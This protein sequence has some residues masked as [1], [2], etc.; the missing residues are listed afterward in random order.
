[1]APALSAWVHAFRLPS[2]RGLRSPA[3]LV[4]ASAIGYARTCAHLSRSLA[5]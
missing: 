5:P 2:A 1:M 4:P 3:S